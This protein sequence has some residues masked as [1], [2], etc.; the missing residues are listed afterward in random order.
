MQQ[1]ARQRLAGCIDGQAAEHMAGDR[2]G[3]NRLGQCWVLLMQVRDTS[4]DRLQ[5]VA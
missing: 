4:T 5:P 2:D 1:V 3:C